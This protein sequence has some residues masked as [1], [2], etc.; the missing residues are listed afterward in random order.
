M[1]PQ[2]IVHIEVSASTSQKLHEDQLVL[3]IRLQAELAAKMSIREN[4]LMQLPYRERHR[5]QGRILGL[6]RFDEHLKH[7]IKSI[8][9][10]ICSVR[11]SPNDPWPAGLPATPH[12]RKGPDR[13]MRSDLW[14]PEWPSD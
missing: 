3:L 6:E 8:H 13:R 14:P 9:V 2:P 7:P 11:R 10:V 1:V 4:L 5:E 12:I